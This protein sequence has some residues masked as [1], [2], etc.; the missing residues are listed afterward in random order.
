METLRKILQRIKSKPGYKLLLVIVIVVFSFDYYLN[1]IAVMALVD[2][3]GFVYA[4]KTGEV[5][6]YLDNP[7]LFSGNE[8]NFDTWRFDSE[9]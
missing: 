3:D 2:L 5:V 1:N 4:T 6:K 7:V 8:V 9:K